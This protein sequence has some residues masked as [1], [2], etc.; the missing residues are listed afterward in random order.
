MRPARPGTDSP[1]GLTAR[2]QEV[3]RLLVAGRTNREIAAAL[4]I[5]HRTAMTHVTHILAKLNVASRTEAA[6]WAVRHGLA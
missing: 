2:E 3:L 4:F 1:A 6:A 5:T